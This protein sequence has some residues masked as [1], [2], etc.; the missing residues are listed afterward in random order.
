M[1]EKKRKLIINE[2]KYGFNKGLNIPFKYIIYKS[3]NTCKRKN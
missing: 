3:K 2:K 1:S